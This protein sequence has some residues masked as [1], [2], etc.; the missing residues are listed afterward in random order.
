MGDENENAPSE[1]TREISLEHARG[2][3]NMES[4][5]FPAVLATE[6][7]A[8]DGHILSIRGMKI[9]PEIPMLFRHS[10]SEQIPG[11]GR[12]TKP[13]KG[14]TDT[15]LAALRVVG[16]FDLGSGGE[17]D[18]FVG[19]RRGMA[20][21]VDSGTLTAMSVRWDEIPGKSKRRRNLPSDHPAFFDADKRGMED[22][23][24]WGWFFEESV[25]REG[26][27][28]AIGADPAALIGR[29]EET[30]DELEHV[31]WVALAR[32]AESNPD[33]V[34]EVVEGFQAIRSEVAKL[35]ERGCDDADIVN[36]MGALATLEASDL[37]PFEFGDGQR[38]H[39]PREAWKQLRSESSREFLA[40]LALRAGPSERVTTRS[41]PGGSVTPA[42]PR[43]SSQKT[44]TVGDLSAD[45]LFGRLGSR[46]SAAVSKTAGRVSGRLT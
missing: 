25:A 35:R 19:I 4:G 43:E 16:R 5:E 44:E 21:M 39:L 46:M 7:E 17:G 9:E 12:I 33:G 28:V 24:Y 34:G 30:D 29:S 3:V 42:A 2:A 14:R 18:P 38:I 36:M 45:E 31:F 40:G 22:P 13:T 11:L 8:S 37:V 26:S 32:S 41:E 6:G 20:H 15:G 10:S 1:I 23:G 27:I